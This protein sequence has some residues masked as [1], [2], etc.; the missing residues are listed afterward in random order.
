MTK[1]PR[2]RTVILI[3]ASNI[4][5][6]ADWCWDSILPPEDHQFYND[7]EYQLKYLKQT[8]LISIQNL[9]KL[10]KIS[11]STYYIFFPIYHDQLMYYY[12]VA[13]N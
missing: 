9:C 10:L 7:F 4:P 12:L 2:S 8:T 3:S 11:T 5:E 1:A 13:K 6:I